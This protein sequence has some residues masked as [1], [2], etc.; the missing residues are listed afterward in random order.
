MMLGMAVPPGRGHNY[1]VDDYIE[2]WSAVTACSN[3]ADADAD[4]LATEIET[5]AAMHS[6]SW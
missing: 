4:Q 5:E 6:G 2:A 1:A 3:W